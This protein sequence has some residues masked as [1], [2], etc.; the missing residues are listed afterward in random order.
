LTERVCVPTMACSAEPRPRAPDAPARADP[1]LLVI[2]RAGD[3]VADVLE[4][5]A[6]ASTARS[7]MHHKFQDRQAGV[8]CR[9][10]NALL[11]GGAA[12]LHRPSRSLRVRAL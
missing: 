12:A 4:E 3:F 11:V 7:C 5:R 10:E 6:A 1:A 8:K 9:L 2:E